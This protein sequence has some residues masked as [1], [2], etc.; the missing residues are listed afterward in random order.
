MKKLRRKR[1]TRLKTDR[2]V[3]ERNKYKNRN[4]SMIVILR[5]FFLFVT[6]VVSTIKRHP[7]V[8]KLVTMAF[9]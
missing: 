7:A 8:C 4:N 3:K 6:F 1:K 9:Y 5:T 2:K